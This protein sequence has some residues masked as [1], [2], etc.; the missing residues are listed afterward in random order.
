MS[1]F[2]D[3]VCVITGAANGIGLCILREFA[4]CGARCA[5]IDTDYE[6]GE[7]IRDELTR[8][9]CDA[10]FYH[11]DIADET[12]LNNFSACVRKR[13]EGLDY[14]I[15]NACTSRRG[16]LSGCSY[17]DFNYVLRVGVSAPYQLTK[18][19]LEYFNENAA[20]VNISSTRS[21]MSQGDTESYSAAKGA[22]ASLTHAMSQSLRGRVRVNS[23]SPG[24]IDVRANVDPHYEKAHSEAD[25]A[26]HPSGR[27]GIPSDIARAVLF[28]CDEENQFINGENITVDGGM[29]RQMVYHNDCGWRYDVGES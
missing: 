29:S 28:L 2:R 6:A 13:F 16:L 10:L 9:N 15:N 27:V 12:T 23:V 19:F 20:I 5:F 8:N 18:L 22:I 1:S 7:H 25:R 26:Q 11:G 21:F 3:K 17:D 24:W 4:R 14:L